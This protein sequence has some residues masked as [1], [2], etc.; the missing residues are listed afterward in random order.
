MY[1][2]GWDIARG[3]GKRKL[4]DTKYYRLQT[5]FDADG[6]P[7]VFGKH[8]TQLMEL[9]SRVCQVEA[10]I[11][12]E[13]GVDKGWST[14]V[15]AHAVELQRGK[16]ISLDIRDC[17]DAVVSD[18]WTF[19][20]ID[21][22]EKERILREAPILEQGIDLLY[23][24]S[25]HAAR[26]VTRQMELWYPLVRQGGWIAFHDVDP[27]PYMRGQRKDNIESEIVWRAVAQVVLDFFYANEDDLLL[28]FHYGDMGM[29]IM[30]KLVPMS[31]AP[32]PLRRLPRRRV[33]L[34]SLA[35]YLTGRA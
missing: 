9:H 28:E 17:S 4:V 32:Q 18:C 6:G 22:T 11:V 27:A 30:Q 33:S 19:L 10:P 20:Q 12:L 13:C 7:G 5:V 23:I 2:H 24:D 29:A 16:L 34:R 8:A 14:G 15:L 1:Y 35:R 31:K 3:R 26:H 21:D 25:L